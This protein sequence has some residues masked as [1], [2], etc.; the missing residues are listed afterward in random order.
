MKPTP[1]D[2]LSGELVERRTLSTDKHGGGEAELRKIRNGERADWD[3]PCWR[4]H[5]R[6]LTDEHDPQV[7]DHVLIRYFGVEPGGMQELYAMRVTRKGV[8]ARLEER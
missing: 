8:Q 4:A 2:V 7:G 1:G 5:L 6:Q 3:V